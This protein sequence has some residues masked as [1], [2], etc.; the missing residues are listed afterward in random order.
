MGI[1]FF[2]FQYTG[3]QQGACRICLQGYSGHA[4][5]GSMKIPLSP[6]FSTA[7][8]V[9][10][11][12]HPL[13]DTNELTGNSQLPDSNQVPDTGAIRSALASCVLSASGWRKIFAC[14]GDEED[15]TSAVSPADLA[16]CALMAHSFADFCLSRVSEREPVII[17]GMDSRPTG[18][19]IADV[20]CRVL[21][22]AGCRVLFGGI[23]AAPEIMAFA[24]KH[25]SFVYISASHNPV[26]HNGIKFGLATGG[27][28]NP[29]EA[30]ILAERLRAQCAEPDAGNKACAAID[31]CDINRLAQCYA[32]IALVKQQALDAYADFSL[33]VLS[34]STDPDVQKRCVDTIQQSL[35]TLR[36]AGEPVA[37][38]A[39]FNG[40]ARA[41]SIDRAFFESLGLDF[42]TINDEPGQIAHRIVPE[43]SSLIPCAELVETLSRTWPA[44]NNHNGRVLLGYVP[45]CDGD[46]GNIVCMDYKTEKPLIPE[47]QEVFALSVLAELAILTASGQLQ[48]NTNGLLEPPA[49]VVVND[50]TS[51]RIDR[52]AGMLGA[53]VYR[54]EVGE[55]RVVELA[56]QKRKEGYTVRI[57]G[58]GSNGG[59]ITHPAA[60]R[61][62]LN[63]VCALL[64]LM[65]PPAGTELSPL[66]IWETVSGTAGLRRGGFKAILDSLPP[67]ITTPVYEPSAILRISTTDHRI[68]KRR[69]QTIFAA[70][71][72]E[73]K[74]ELARR[75]GITSWE[76][77]GYQGTVETPDLQD[78]SSNGTGGLKIIFR[79]ENNEDRAFIWMRGSGTEPVFRILA[80]TAGSDPEMERYLLEWQTELV[81]E[82]DREI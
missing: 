47:A 71:W 36:I 41:C 43:G 9:N 21:T 79:T 5:L 58:E 22:G 52:L 66:D 69:Y 78:F 61:D 25:D 26:G 62:P 34:G 17:V 67:F 2:S 75:F 15:K 11:A 20:F 80:D 31:A 4:I 76:A 50:P 18:P 1:L 7:S 29:A 53:R 6:S 48:R 8:P 14:S 33:Y 74:A 27:V 19:L 77:R 56:T 23:M 42:F 44:E 12:Q 24:R 37:V 45:D 63:T 13:R 30:D 60:V 81:L 35:S 32:R 38:I 70:R 16:L 49:A 64:R 3:N 65:L 73:R 28:L 40:S 10:P 51:M 57:L 55:A 39:D 59:T 82:A 54:A 46:R 68:L 72:L